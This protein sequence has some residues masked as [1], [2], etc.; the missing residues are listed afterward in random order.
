ME[1]KHG[2][3]VTPVPSS[4]HN[5]SLELTDFDADHQL[6]ALPGLSLLV[7]TSAGCASCRWARRRLPELP[8]SVARIGWIDAG[9]NGGLVQR[10]GVFH[11]PAMFLV[12][13]GR[14]LGALSSE[15]NADALERA[16]GDALCNEPDE[17]P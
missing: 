15:L 13:D 4:P 2:I 16:I 14:F 9:E 5:V 3:T 17:L 1:T 10:Y 12:G 11:L 8:L 6:L 7:F